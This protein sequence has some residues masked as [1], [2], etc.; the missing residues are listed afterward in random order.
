M[1]DTIAQDVLQSIAE[2]HGTPCYV[3]FLDVVTRQAEL[4][5][6]AFGRRFEISYAV[7]ANPNSALIRRLRNTVDA[8]DVSSIGE[9]RRALGAGWAPDR[10]S[11]TGPGK[12]ASELIEAVGAGIGSIVIESMAEARTL[13]GIAAQAGTKQPIMVRIAPAT[14]P[15]GFGVRMAGRPSQFGIDEE[16]IDEAVGEIRSLEHLD[17]RG[18]H[19][20]SGTQC[21]NEQSIAENLEIF[22]GLFQRISNDHN[23]SPQKLV[24]GSG[25]GIPYYEA[26]RSLDL[27][28]IAGR[29]VPQLDRLKS[30]TRFGQTVLVLELGRFLVGP[31]GVYL[32]RVI[33]MKRS[34]GVNIGVCDGGMNHHLAACGHLGSVIHRNFQMFK[35]TPSVRDAETAPYDLVG[36]L[37]TS[38]DTLARNVAMPGLEV[39]DVIAIRSSGAYGLTAS[40]IH[41]IS[42]NPPKEYLVSL[43]D[44]Q[45]HVEDISEY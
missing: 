5:R 6:E 37:C 43:Q 36:P 38:I 35:V 8:L 1:T 31:A 25:F 2:E 9:L 11:F 19:I 7:K 30:Q 12:Q 10:I 32:T 24:F 23:L 17:L 15:R 20:F 18:L 14:V 27:R 33:N 34:R 28:A 39:G 22:I 40:P 13:D 3:Y 42:H 29:I 44:G 45:S 26:D 4:L 21:L 16:Q 41:F